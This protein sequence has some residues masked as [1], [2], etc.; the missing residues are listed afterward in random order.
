MHP[1]MVP[2][3]QRFVTGIFLSGVFLVTTLAYL[4]W[5]IAGGYP[6]FVPL[7]GSVIMNDPMFG[8][9]DGRKW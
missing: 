7:N 3:T 6:M 9:V 5:G 2:C 1:H 8:Q 4:L